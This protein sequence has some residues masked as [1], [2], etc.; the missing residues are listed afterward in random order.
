M[1]GADLREKARWCYKERLDTRDVIKVLATDGTPSMVLYRLIAGVEGEP[2]SAQL[3]M[4]FNKLNIAAFGNCVIGRGAEFGTGVRALPLN[5]RRHQRG[6]CAEDP[7]N[8]TFTREV[9][10]GDN[11]AGRNVASSGATS[12]SGPERR[13]SVRCR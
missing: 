6:R 4:V 9:T 11:E 1:L 3:E 13:L 7:T 12:T 5:R 2:T 10:I 8:S